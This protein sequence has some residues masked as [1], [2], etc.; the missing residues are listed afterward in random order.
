MKNEPISLNLRGTAVNN[1]KYRTAIWTGNKCQITVMDIPVGSDIG[2]EIHKVHDQIIYIESGVAVAELGDDEQNLTKTDL[3]PGFAV[4]VPAGT[5][6]NVVN[7]GS[8]PL[9][10]FSVY[11]PIMHQIDTIHNTKDDGYKKFA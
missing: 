8:E 4:L 2:I 9:K 1:D 10:L 6:H 3:K 7:T 5:W 11:A